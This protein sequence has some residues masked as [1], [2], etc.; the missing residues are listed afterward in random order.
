MGKSKEKIEK[1]S[2][3]IEYPQRRFGLI[4]IEKGF[5][6]VDELWEGLMRQ[7]AQSAEAK[8][9]HIG[10]ILKD[11]GYMDV[12]QIDAVLEAMKQE[13]ESKKP[14]PELPKGSGRGKRKKSR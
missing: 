6:T 2:V 7:K 10:M 11:M 9:R 8:R 13:T 14:L 5:I 12:P 3:G 4:A 1:L